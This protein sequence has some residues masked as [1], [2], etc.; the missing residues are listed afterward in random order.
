MA[1]NEGVMRL[2][3]R[4]INK[5]CGLCKAYTANKSALEENTREPR[6]NTREEPDMCP[7]DRWLKNERMVEAT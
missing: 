7:I 2:H 4:W 6:N 1:L 3:T 5:I